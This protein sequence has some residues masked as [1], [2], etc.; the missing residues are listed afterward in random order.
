MPRVSQKGQVTIPVEIRE[1]LGIRPGDEVTFEETN[2]GY[3]LRKLPAEG[4]FQKWHGAF[5][6]DVSMEERMEELRG[7]PLRRSEEQTK[8]DGNGGE[9]AASEGQ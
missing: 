1:K 5:E 4:R 7:R 8:N 2:D 9:H 3:A 6:S